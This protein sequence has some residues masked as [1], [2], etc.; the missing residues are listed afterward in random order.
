MA[1]REGSWWSRAWG[2][3]ARCRVRACTWARRCTKPPSSHRCG[4]STRRRAS[5]AWAAIDV[6][7]RFV[8]AVQAA[9]RR[10]RRRDGDGVDLRRRHARMATWWLT[11]AL[12]VRGCARRAIASVRRCRPS[13]SCSARLRSA[14][15]TRAAVVALDRRLDPRGGAM[16]MARASRRRVVAVS[17]AARRRAGRAA[18]STRNRFAERP[19]CRRRPRPPRPASSRSETTPDPRSRSATRRRIPGNDGAGRSRAVAGQLKNRGLHS[20]SR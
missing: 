18:R 4:A 14:T 19:P 15:A 20:P 10:D 12:A 16:R 5:L 7:S 6:A 9:R 1:S 11:L 8:D 13:V 2:A 3:V 17:R